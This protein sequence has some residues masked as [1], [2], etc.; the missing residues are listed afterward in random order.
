MSG[1]RLAWKKFS[2]D[3]LAFTGFLII[4]TLVLTALLAG[5]YLPIRRIPTR[6]IPH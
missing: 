6:F 1:L 5:V 2:R 4:V 3:R